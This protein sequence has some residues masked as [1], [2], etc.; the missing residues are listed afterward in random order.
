[1]IYITNEVTSI[2]NNKSSFNSEMKCPKCNKITLF[3][4]S[5]PKRNTFWACSDKNKCCFTINDD[6]GKPAQIK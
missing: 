5:I 2:K 4:I 1:M 6:N 3:K